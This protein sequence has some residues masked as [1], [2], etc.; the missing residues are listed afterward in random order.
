MTW[1]GKSL[2]KEIILFDI[3]KNYSEK[4]LRKPADH[5]ARNSFRS[6]RSNERDR[7]DIDEQSERNQ[8]ALNEF[9]KNQDENEHE[10]E[11]DKKALWIK[12]EELDENDVVNDI[13]KVVR[14]NEERDA[15]W[16]R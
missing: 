3:K 8:C 6:S 12:E 5:A 4:R 10:N 14:F 11:Q 13:D 2:G 16:E 15:S 1:F 9:Y 7:R